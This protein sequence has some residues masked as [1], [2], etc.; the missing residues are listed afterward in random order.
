MKEYFLQCNDA[1]RS[2]ILVQVTYEIWLLI[3]NLNEF[4][5]F[6]SGH[7]EVAMFAWLRQWQFAFELNK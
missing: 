7:D 5:Y 3:A 4:E 2:K 1:L 6:N